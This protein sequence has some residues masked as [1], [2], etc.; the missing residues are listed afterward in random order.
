MA[1]QRVQKHL[2]HLPQKAGKKFSYKSKTKGLNVN[3]ENQGAP[4]PVADRYEM[5]DP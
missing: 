4:V 1:R 3:V 5:Q 2:E